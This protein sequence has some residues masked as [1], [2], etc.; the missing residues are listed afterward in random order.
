MSKSFDTPC[1]GICSTVYGDEV[2]LGCGRFYNEIIDWNSY[3]AD[4]KGSVFKRL[5]A[6]II[7]ATEDKLSVVDKDLLA[8]QLERLNIRHNKAENPLCWAYHLLRR[9]HYRI[10]EID[11]YGIKI[12]LSHSELSLTVLYQEIEKTFNRLS[13]EA[14]LAIKAKS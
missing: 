3:H 2:C 14:F 8:E 10:T 9:G 11:K 7:A 5:E 6:I 12:E 13:S 4:Q 1:V